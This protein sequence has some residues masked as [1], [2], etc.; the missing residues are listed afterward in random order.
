[1]RIALSLPWLLASDSKHG[2]GKKAYKRFDGRGI[3][4]LI[5]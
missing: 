5:L 2:L 3:I 1:M 4:L